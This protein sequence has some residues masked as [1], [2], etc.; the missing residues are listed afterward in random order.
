VADNTM[1]ANN[2]IA[3]TISGNGLADVTIHPS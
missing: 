2:V 3:N 1:T